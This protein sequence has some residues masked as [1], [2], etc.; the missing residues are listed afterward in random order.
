MSNDASSCVELPSHPVEDKDI[1]LA[2]P[3]EAPL[4]FAPRPRSTMCLS[5]LADFASPCASMLDGPHQVPGS[6]QVSPGSPR[7]NAKAF[8]FFQ[9]KQIRLLSPPAQSRCRCV[10][11][12]TLAEAG[13]EPNALLP[14]PHPAPDMVEA[15]ALGAP[16]HRVR[17]RETLFSLEGSPSGA[18]S[19]TRL[20]SPGAPETPQEAKPCC[21]GEM[22][23]VGGPVAPLG[24]ETDLGL[25]DG[26]EEGGARAA[27]MR[28][29]DG[30][31]PLRED[32]ERSDTTQKGFFQKRESVLLLEVGDPRASSWPRILYSSDEF[33]EAHSTNSRDFYR[34]IG[35]ENAFSSPKRTAFSS[36]SRTPAG[37]EETLVSSSANWESPGFFGQP[38]IPPH[39]TPT[40]LTEICVEKKGPPA[41]RAPLF[42]VYTLS[43]SLRGQAQG[44]E[45]NVG[46]PGY[47]PS[48]EDTDGSP[49]TENKSFCVEFSESFKVRK[50]DCEAGPGGHLENASLPLPPSP[51]RGGRDRLILEETRRGR[52][53]GVLRQAKS[54]PASNAPCETPAGPKDQA[55][56][57]RHSGTDGEIPL[58]PR[59]FSWIS[60][61]TSSLLTSIPDASWAQAT[62]SVR[63]EGGTPDLNFL[64]RQRLSR[65]SVSATS[66]PSTPSNR[67][68][69]HASLPLG[70]VSGVQT[71]PSPG[72]EAGAWAWPGGAETSRSTPS[73]ATPGSVFPTSGVSTAENRLPPQPPSAET[74]VTPLAGNAALFVVWPATAP[75]RQANLLPTVAPPEYAWDGGRLSGSFP[76]TVQ[77]EGGQYEVGGLPE[78]QRQRQQDVLEGEAG[79]A[80]AVSSGGSGGARESRRRPA[81]RR[82]ARQKAQA[83]GAEEV[84][85]G[86]VEGGRERRRGRPRKASQSGSVLAKTRTSTPENQRVQTEDSE[87]LRHSKPL[88]RGAAAASALSSAGER[89]PGQPR[90]S[91][92]SAGGKSE[93]RPQKPV[94]ELL[95]PSSPAD[96]AK[97]GLDVRQPASEALRSTYTWRA[98][99]ELAT[100]HVGGVSPVGKND[101]DQTGRE[102]CPLSATQSRDGFPLDCVF[103][104]HESGEVSD[105]PRVREEAK[106]VAENEGEGDVERPASSRVSW[107]HSDSASVSSEKSK[108]SFDECDQAPSA[109]GRTVG[110]EGAAGVRSRSGQGGEEE[111]AARERGSEMKSD[112]TRHTRMPTPCDERRN[113]HPVRGDSTEWRAT[114]AETETPSSFWKAPVCAAKQASREPSS[115][116]AKPANHAS[117]EVQGTHALALLSDPGTAWGRQVPGEP[118]G[119]READACTAKMASS[120]VRSDEDFRAS[121]SRSAGCPG[122]TSFLEDTVETPGAAPTV[123]RVPL[124]PSFSSGATGLPSGEAGLHL[125]S[126]VLCVPTANSS[127]RTLEGSEKQ[128]ESRPSFESESGGKTHPDESIVLPSSALHCRPSQPPAALCTSLPRGSL[129]SSHD[130]LPSVSSLSSPAPSS[131][132]PCFSASLPQFVQQSSPVEKGS[133]SVSFSVPWS[134]PACAP[135]SASSSEALQAVL[136][137][138][139]RTGEERVAQ[140]A[141]DSAGRAAEEPFGSPGVALDS[142]EEIEKESSPGTVSQLP[143]KRSMCHQ[144]EAHSTRVVRRRSGKG[145]RREE[146]LLHMDS[147]ATPVSL[148]LERTHKMSVCKSPTDDRETAWD[149]RAFSAGIGATEPMHAVPALRANSLRAAEASRQPGDLRPAGEAA[150]S[151]EGTANGSAGSRHQGRRWGPARGESP[152]FFPGLSDATGQ[153]SFK[154]NCARNRG[155]GHTDD[156]D[157]LALA[158]LLSLPNTGDETSESVDPSLAAACDPKGKAPGAETGGKRRRYHLTNTALESAP[159]REEEATGRCALGAHCEGEASS[160]EMP[161]TALPAAW[162]EGRLSGVSV[163]LPGVQARARELETT[164]LSQNAQ[165][166]QAELSDHR[167]ETQTG[168]TTAAPGGCAE[169]E[170]DSKHCDTKMHAAALAAPSTADSTPVGHEPELGAEKKARILEEATRGVFTPDPGVDGGIG[171]PS[172]VPPPIFLQTPCSVAANA[173]EKTH[174]ELK[175]PTLPPSMPTAW[176]VCPG[177][178]GRR[179][180][181]AGG[182]GTHVP[183]LEPNEGPQPAGGVCGGEALVCAPSGD[184]RVPDEGGTEAGVL[185]QTV[186]FFAETQAQTACSWVH[187]NEAKH[188]PEL[189]SLESM[190]TTVGSSA[191]EARKAGSLPTAVFPTASGLHPASQEADSTPG[192]EATPTNAVSEGLAVASPFAVALE[193]G[194]AWRP[195]SWNG[196][197]FG[198][199]GADPAMLRRMRTQELLQDA[200]P[201]SPER[202]SPASCG[203]AVGGETWGLGAAV[204]PSAGSGSSHGGAGPCVKQGIPVHAVPSARPSCLSLDPPRAS[205]SLAEGLPAVLSASSPAWPRNAQALFPC[206]PGFVESGPQASPLAGLAAGPSGASPPVFDPGLSPFGA[207]ELQPRAGLR[208]G[209]YAPSVEPR[210]PGTG[211]PS[212]SGPGAPAE[213][214]QPP[215]AFATVGTVPRG[216]GRDSGTLELDEAGK[217]TLPIQG[218]AGLRGPTEERESMLDLSDARW[219]DLRRQ[220]Y[221]RLGDKGRTSIKSRIAR[222]LRANPELRAQA[223][224]VSG[225][226][227]A[228]TKQ[229]YQLAELCGFY[230]VLPPQFQPAA[231]AADPLHAPVASETPDQQAPG[232]V[233]ARGHARVV[234]TPQ[235]ERLPALEGSPLHARSEGQS[236]SAFADELISGRSEECTTWPAFTGASDHTGRAKVAGD[237]AQEHRYVPGSLAQTQSLP[238][239]ASS[240]GFEFPACYS[241][242][243]MAFVQEARESPPAPQPT[244]DCGPGLARDSPLG[245][246]LYTRQE[247]PFSF[248]MQRGLAEPSGSPSEFRFGVSAFQAFQT[249]A[250]LVAG[251]SGVSPALGLPSPQNGGTSRCLDSPG[252]GAGTQCLSPSSDTSLCSTTHSSCLSRSAGLKL[253][254]VRGGTRVEEGKLVASAAPGLPVFGEAVRHVGQ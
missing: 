217:R 67:R 152:Q 186:P 202:G 97:F 209:D 27:W 60:P 199:W 252:S 128:S 168:A 10:L 77:L 174:A 8:P 213:A 31:A 80:I 95:R 29:D 85:R 86:D 154:E 120:V 132:S 123:Q 190:E 17:G 96:G 40:L 179:E 73:R 167:P 55:G 2:A 133:P 184:E 52:P 163:A 79:D 112:D 187:R 166:G 165:D 116:D 249:N 122:E 162:S 231:R 198:P 178:P 230:D 197:R 141:A 195:W 118:D 243:D 189:P 90:L 104:G 134:S 19:S 71:P 103:R 72:S 135:W 161:S 129:S 250:R 62:S 113:A 172:R 37:M 4:L 21:A 69:L 100:A 153:E 53:H 157:G 194:A 125:G 182:A 175:P 191:E 220:G 107:T 82:V 226:R 149:G 235:Q 139:E 207:H 61:H 233:S 215:F 171:S 192:H 9:S 81:S 210:S 155:V 94:E 117:A 18:A 221:F 151:R 87:D 136:A 50:E 49:A 159:R 3:G 35:N 146:E 54:F 119:R 147:A 41:L 224:A 244:E 203:P 111:S 148:E 248:C 219:R 251:A 20:L 75:G 92:L 173:E 225:V 30:R 206:L 88:A 83:G 74:P 64:S 169:S 218:D 177:A 99:G 204:G 150:A 115:G 106:L 160:Q 236:S 181:P 164:F 185:A 137:R 33:P 23:K 24:F 145:E 58:D 16:R 140:E 42:S 22:L 47:F 110:D 11:S 246:R 156:G 216:P 131:L 176:P 114:T 212:V 38:G 13:L 26:Q 65:D 228:T 237:S 70:E 12:P 200:A 32:F 28:S 143:R 36:L 227:S 78:E 51:T 5:S 142:R 196:D 254:D 25:G 238:L 121:P 105:S 242:G 15:F 232:G 245:E 229:L 158:T 240:H 239:K 144:Q 193:T 130:T 170:L 253:F 89:N 59:S 57:A 84:E 98:G 214:P 234:R 34:E 7:E 222:E 39:A 43:E 48:R 101:A 56:M 14:P 127:V 44:Q 180:T 211:Y 247:P 108:T 76:C 124:S 201:A 126:S 188:A 66:R 93:T 138:A 45:A 68:D 223:A 1:L 109:S 6:A 63:E 205:G 183:P 91:H 102:F 208:E 46:V 241:S